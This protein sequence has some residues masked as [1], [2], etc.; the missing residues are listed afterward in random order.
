ML[1][2]DYTMVI[3]TYTVFG[4]T[5]LYVHRLVGHKSLLFSNTYAAACML[6]LGLDLATSREG[7]LSLYDACLA[8]CMSL[9]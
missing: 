9:R 2:N 7:F 1:W 3:V 6:D 5:C 4:S 8:T